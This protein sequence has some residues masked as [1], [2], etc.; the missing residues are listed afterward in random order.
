MRKNNVD[1][2]PLTRVV[3]APSN[4]LWQFIDLMRCSSSRHELKKTFREALFHFGYIGFVSDMSLC[5][6]L[7]DDEIL[8]PNHLP[9]KGTK[10][11]DMD[12][13]DLYNDIAQ[14]TD[15][16]YREY[17][18]TIEQIA[19]EQFESDMGK[20]VRGY[21]SGKLTPFFTISD[22]PYMY[23][24]FVER[25]FEVAR[26]FVHERI[27]DRLN[28]PISQGNK[29][30]FFLC[31]LTKDSQSIENISAGV[32]LAN[33]YN[34]LCVHFESWTCGDSMENGRVALGAT[35]IECIEWAVAGKT[36]E[37]ISKITGLSVHTVRYHMEQA[38]IRYG[39]ATIQQTLVRAARDYN[40]DPLGRSRFGEANRRIYV[41][42]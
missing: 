41:L 31:L 30:S 1:V 7:S 6:I 21:F 34:D 25:I 10:A 19:K 38:K 24:E 5:E 18:M 27:H 26:K 29:L 15:T 9:R 20:A 14:R 28:I 22:S 23:T 12:S 17:L 35:Q 4:P 37:D 13:D 8:H 3:D 33:T 2:S 32:I 42:S 11:D 36:V 40:L 16:L 39:Y